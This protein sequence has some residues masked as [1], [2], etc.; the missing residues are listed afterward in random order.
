MKRRNDSSI[1][2]GAPVRQNMR[3]GTLT[4]AVVASSL[5]ESVSSIKLKLLYKLI[6]LEDFDISVHTQLC[7]ENFSI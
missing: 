6:L 5:L 7:I 4:N 3:T 2:F 1:G